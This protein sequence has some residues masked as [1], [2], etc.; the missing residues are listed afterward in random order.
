VNCGTY[1]LPR[2]K[3]DGSLNV[4][5]PKHV[6]TNT[7]HTGSARRGSKD[8]K[9]LR[10]AVRLMEQAESTTQ[11]SERS[12]P[13][14]E[15]AEI[16]IEEN[17]VPTSVSS[18]SSVHSISKRPAPGA[19]PSVSYWGISLRR[20]LWDACPLGA[21]YLWTI[22]LGLAR[23]RFNRASCEG[24]HEDMM[25]YSP[26]Q[27]LHLFNKGPRPPLA[28]RAM[29]RPPEVLRLA[30]TNARMGG[31]RARGLGAWSTKR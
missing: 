19:S 28:Q 30:A 3:L 25:W 5:A 8:T 26:K 13:G 10:D 2:D 11:K 1:Y 27:P 31:A 18:Y 12:R 4:A 17:V 23:V 21:P 16:A 20:A 24:V 29:Q 6:N 14:D 9:S 22:I 15:D 7:T